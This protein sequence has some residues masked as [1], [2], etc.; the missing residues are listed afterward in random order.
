MQRK[1]GDRFVI[2]KSSRREAHEY[3]TYAAYCSA[4]RRA[5]L[6]PMTKY[7]WSSLKITHT[8]ISRAEYRVRARR[9]K[10]GR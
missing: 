2:G 4:V 3:A 7:D 6:K 8:P 10:D 9:A 1:I 5:G